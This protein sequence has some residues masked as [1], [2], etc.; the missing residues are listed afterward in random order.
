M[1][2]KDRLEN[3]RYALVEAEKAVNELELSVFTFDPSWEHTHHLTRACSRAESSMSKL[4]RQI[5][6]ANVTW[7]ADAAKQGPHAS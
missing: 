3:A 2:I 4:R 6:L 1:E 5:D 7:A